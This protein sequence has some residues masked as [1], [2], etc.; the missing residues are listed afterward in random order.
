MSINLAPLFAATVINW[1]SS[2]RLIFVALIT[3]P[4]LILGIIPFLRINKKRR[5]SSKHLI[6]FIIHMS[7]ILILSFVFAGV[8]KTE[9]SEVVHTKESAVIFVVD[10]SDSSAPSKDRMNKYMHDLMDYIKETDKKAG[11]K[12][13]EFGLVVFGGKEN[14]GII[15]TKNGS[16]AVLP[17]ELKTETED[18]LLPYTK[19]PKDPQRDQSN[20]SAALLKANDIFA[21]KKYNDVNKKVVLLSDGREIGGNAIHVIDTLNRNEITLS[22]MLF[23]FVNDKTEEIYREIQVI[24]LSTNGKVKKGEKVEAE[25]VLESTSKISNV[26][27]ILSD[28][29]GNRIGDVAFVDVPE[30]R[31]LHTIVFEP[32]VYTPD[33]D[34]D[35]VNMIG[36][37]KVDSTG[38]QAIKV[39]VIVPTGDEIL[40]LNNTFYSWYTF[41]TKGKILL[42][43]GDTQQLSQ[44]NKA[45]DKIDLSEYD[46]EKVAASQF[47][48]SLEKMLEYDEIIFMN[49]DYTRLTDDPTQAIRNIKRY[50]EEV[51]R[52]VL[53]TLGDNIFDPTGGEDGKGA[54][55]DSPIND[56][57]PVKLQLDEEKET[58]GMVL[59]VD[60][61]SSMK[62]LVS[63]S[64]VICKKC[65]Y[66][67][68]TAPSS[69]V[70]TNCDEVS[71]FPKP[72]R[73]H[74]V[75][76]S[77]KKVVKESTFEPEDYIGVIVFDQ[78]YH[79]ALEIQPI[80]DEANREVLCE[81]MAYEF[82]HYYYAHYLDK[83]TGE[84]SDIRVNLKEDG[85]QGYGNPYLDG[86]DAKYI[87]PENY[88]A[89]GEDK[90]TGDCIKSRG[91]SYKWPIQEASAMLA[92]A[93]NMAGSL[94]IKQ[95]V[96]MS[97]GAPND[98][99]SGYEGIVERMAKGGTVT[100][101]IAIGIT[102]DE[103]DAIA[104]LE[105]IS[106]A[107]KGDL[108]LVNKASDLDE[109]L[110]GIVESIK[111]ELLNKDITVEPR[112]DSM[113]S[114]VHEGMS[115]IEYDFIHGYYGSQIKE[116]AERV[117]YVDNLRPLYAEWDYGL[118]KVCIFMSDLGDENW[119]GEMFDDTDGRKNT[120]LIKNILVAPIQKRID[121][122]GLEYE[123]SRDDK[124][125]TL[126]VETYTDLSLRDQVING[127]TY[128]DVIKAQ[129]Y[130]F[131]KAT[132]VWQPYTESKF[133]TNKD[134]AIPIADRKYQITI[135][136]DSIEEAYVIILELTRVRVQT[137]GE[138]TLYQNID[139]SV[140]KDDA[141]K[142]RTALIVAGGIL[143]EYDI[144]QDTNEEGRTLLTG[145]SEGGRLLELD[146][147]SNDTDVDVE[148]PD[149]GEDDG[150]QV[151]SSSALSE[152]AKPDKETTPLPGKPESIDIPLI[153]L[154][155]IL[156][157]LDLVFRNFVI[158]RR[159]RTPAQ[160]TDEEQIASMRGR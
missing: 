52:G 22:C 99:G 102:K 113:N 47:P 78:D 98:K 143:Q 103:K 35:Q 94:E 118:G 40:T 112:V 21:D 39:D 150:E 57:F 65:D 31:S 127:Q 120:I 106:V 155:L 13:T 157:V 123:A 24:S 134:I 149:G 56:L 41:E 80:G 115:E 85:A 28:V 105:K 9:N 3:I 4:A 73:Y 124:T 79:V 60:L 49:V 140:D 137:V 61:S 34:P 125:I 89:G 138:N 108:F 153:I 93:Q 5:T 83:L 130:K 91:T 119:T 141:V 139:Y 116:N 59:V 37:D 104:E 26:Q 159:K 19:G 55:V 8:S 23:D 11:V 30:G 32:T 2:E 20:I 54:F 7:L 70:C 14:D 151:E 76:E 58:I 16:S 75:L 82:E 72:T 42:V 15:P 6:P 147:I 68:E 46:V 109:D 101:S 95:V 160:M 50:V 38:V 77:V 132:G 129:L 100:S 121:S 88:N 154:A 84:E 18:F 135:P 136:T 122:T 12:E 110:A 152:F 44:I 148:A 43:Y 10:M 66:Y 67:Y 1:P 33:V 142:D 158:K 63:N 81:K 90:A 25:V 117:I 27:L 128:R 64:G 48:R 71:T 133:N 114:T 51:G 69:G 87:L 29:A 111:G 126:K 156:F 74:V 131:D 97:D 146:R 17:G 144:L 92:R 62:E 96:F 86:P 36:Q 145:L 53:F 107:G 45:G